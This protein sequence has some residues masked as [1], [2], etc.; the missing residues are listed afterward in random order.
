MGNINVTQYNQT[1]GAMGDANQINSAFLTIQTVIN[2]DIED[3]NIKAAAAIAASKIVRDTDGTLAANSDSNIPSQKAVKTYADAITN[4][5]GGTMAWT[6][7]T[8]A[9]ITGWTS[10]PGE[11][12]FSYLCLGTKTVVVNVHALGT[13][14]NA[15][16]TSFSTPALGNSVAGHVKYASAYG[17]D[18]AAE[19]LVKMYVEAGTATIKTVCHGSVNGWTTGTH[20]REVSGQ[21]IYELA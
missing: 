11:L 5:L 10:T 2:G 6:P 8:P 13:V 14:T 1:P 3:A 12:D 15:V 9:T 20:A 7:Y 4:S 19:V 21:I 18:E 16:T 17:L